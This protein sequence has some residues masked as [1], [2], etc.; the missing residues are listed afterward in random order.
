MSVP[1]STIPSWLE[2]VRA[3]G[4]VCAAVVIG[5]LGVFIAWQQWR[6]NKAGFRE[7]FF[8][9]RFEVYEETSDLVGRVFSGRGDIL[10]G[11]KSVQESLAEFHSARHRATFLFSGKLDD[12]LKEIHELMI[13]VDS[14]RTH[15]NNYVSDMKKL[16]KIYRE[17]PEE[18]KPF[19]S[20]A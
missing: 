16:T 4:P 6:V 11:E 9:R 3:L 2:Y 10:S 12:R 15:G 13:D 8:D 18:F 20:V 1:A 5:G 7:K 14:A 17:L 19:L